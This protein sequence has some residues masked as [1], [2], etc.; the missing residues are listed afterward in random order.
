MTKGVNIVSEDVE[1]GG[2]DNTFD[3]ES[4]LRNN[5][6]ALKEAS[7]TPRPTF[8]NET[9]NNDVADT[10]NDEVTMVLQKDEGQ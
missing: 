2:N 1:I 6:E 10:A 5:V 7:G 9:L 3:E 8:V 4:V